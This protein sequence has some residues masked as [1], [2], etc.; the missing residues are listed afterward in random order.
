MSEPFAVPMSREGTRSMWSSRRRSKSR[1]FSMKQACP[2]GTAVV[3]MQRSFRVQRPQSR[4]YLGPANPFIEGGRQVIRAKGLGWR[5]ERRKLSKLWEGPL[6]GS[7]RY[8]DVTLASCA[9]PNKEQGLTQSGRQLLHPRH[10]IW[11]PLSSLELAPTWLLAA[12][13]KSHCRDLHV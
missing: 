10:L 9:T 8:G 12:S 5:L 4:S 1:C 7:S 6:R 11:A 13:D 2:T 3:G